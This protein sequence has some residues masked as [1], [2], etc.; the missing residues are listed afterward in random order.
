MSRIPSLAV[1][2]PLRRLPAPSRGSPAWGRSVGASGAGEAS[3]RGRRRPPAPPRGPSASRRAAGPGLP[4]GG[5][6]LGCHRSRSRP[7]PRSRSRRRGGSRPLL[8]TRLLFPARVTG[9]SPGSRRRPPTRPRPGPHDLPEQAAGPAESR[10]LVSSSCRGREGNFAF[11][12][13]GGRRS[14]AEVSRAPGRRGH[15]GASHTWRGPR[16]GR[17]TDCPVAA[18]L[19]FSLRSPGGDCGRTFTAFTCLSDQ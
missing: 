17:I 8:L 10:A 3:R 19:V 6:E 13:Q 1:W 15:D 18:V 7:P 4:P 11:R 16:K 9:P 2:P 5:A 12:G 14:G